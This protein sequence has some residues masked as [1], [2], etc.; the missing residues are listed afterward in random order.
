M[1]HDTIKRR[2]FRFFDSGDVARPGRLA[3]KWGP[4]HP[5]FDRAAKSRRRGR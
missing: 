1:S 5:I 2:V 3:P 4:G